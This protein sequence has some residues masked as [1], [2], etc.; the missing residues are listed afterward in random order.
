ME[1]L[2]RHGDGKKIYEMVENNYILM[3]LHLLL[4][5]ISCSRKSIASL[6]KLGICI[7]KSIETLFFLQT[8]NIISITKVLLAEKF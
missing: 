7:K 4:I 1:P 6:K 2:K 5:L 8:S 3:H